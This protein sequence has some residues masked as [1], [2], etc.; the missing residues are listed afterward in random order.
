MF[1]VL[2]L[3]DFPEYDTQDNAY[4]KYYERIFLNRYLSLITRPEFSVAEIGAGKNLSIISALNVSSIHVIDPLDGKVGGGPGR[5]SDDD[6]FVGRIILHKCYVGG[7]GSECLSS[8]SFDIV[9]SM[10]VLEHIGQKES[11]YSCTFTSSPPAE[12]EALRDAFCKDLY[13]IIKPGGYSVHLIDHAVRNITY[14]NNFKKA[15]FVFSVEN[16]DIEIN[17]KYS[18]SILD[19]KNAIRQKIRWRTKKEFNRREQRLHSVLLVV[20][21]KPDCPE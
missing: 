18:N 1:R 11:G 6:D 19:Q 15:G 9:F 13:R 5:L 10:S 2:T 14:Y 16:S 21:R 20:C 8:D 12:Q 4:V 3:D 17:Q 7:E